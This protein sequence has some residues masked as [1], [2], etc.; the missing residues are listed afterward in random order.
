V[1]IPASPLRF[2]MQIPELLKFGVQI[3]ELLTSASLFQQCATPFL[4]PQ[5]AQNCG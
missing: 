1:Q 3:P 2:G 5:T 4:R